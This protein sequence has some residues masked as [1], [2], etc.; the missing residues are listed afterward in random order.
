MDFGL[1]PPEVN[2]GL[3][4][5]GPGAGPLLAA[6]ASWDAVAAQLEAAAAGCS[7]ELSGLTGRWLGP[8]SLRMAVAGT[9]QVGW[10][11]A[12]AAQ[13]ARTA[14]QAYT[15]AAAYEAA[16][17]MTVPPPVIVANRTL[18]TALVATNFFGQNTPAIAVTEAH[19]LEMWVQ[20]ATAMYT[21]AADAETASTLQPF[22]E[23]QQTTNPNGQTDQANAVAKATSEA[24]SARTQ[25]AV[26]AASQS[27]PV[28]YTA[29]APPG[30]TV[31]IG[32]GSSQI[33][34]VSGSVTV[35]G[36]GTS[37]TQ[38]LGASITV[39]P[40]TTIQL[41]ATTGAFGS[42][43]GSS[44]YYP[45]GSFVTAGLAGP[46]TLTPDKGAT[47]ILGTL[48]AGSVGSVTLTANAAQP[49]VVGSFTGITMTAGAAGASITNMQGTLT[50]AAVT[51]VAP[52]AGGSASGFAVSAAPVAAA[53]GLAGT[54]GIQPQLNVVGLTEWAQ[55][56][57]GADLAAGLGEA[58][59]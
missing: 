52:I 48:G 23:P 27:V 8:S 47:G 59:G 42:G 1:L 44:S 7:A 30:S 37:P 10:L 16:Y 26:Q 57:S 36:P 38:V 15:A 35:V 19:Y 56:F 28:G 6:A 33:N 54:A 14:A 40:G 2:S 11:Q 41:G 43:P 22:D 51:P 18:K 50:I 21:Y 58:V 39:N 20:D 34:I 55:G 24:T 46:I 29:D 9:R 4:Y 45:A 17:A 53:P 13:A 12:S 49:G 5:T 3:M 25:A 32:P 31:T